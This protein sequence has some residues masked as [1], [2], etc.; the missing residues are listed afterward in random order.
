M[1]ARVGHDTARGKDARAGYRAGTFLVSQ[2]EDIIGHVSA[3]VY[4]SHSTVEIAMQRP[5]AF[6][7][8]DLNLSQA[9]FRDFYTA[10]QVNMDIHQAGDQVFLRAVDDLRI[11]QPGWIEFSS[12]DFSDAVIPDQDADLV[13]RL[14]AGA[15]D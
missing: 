14:P 15:V 9:L 13:Y 1:A 5:D 4:G 12:F 3:V 11:F 7:R 10:C 6:V 2:G 8:I